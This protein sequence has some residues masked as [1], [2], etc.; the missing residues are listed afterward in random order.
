MRS[1]RRWRSA[2]F[3]KPSFLFVGSRFAYKNFPFLLRAFAKASESNPRIR[4]RIAGAPLNIEERWQI[5]LLGISDRV[6]AVTYPD[7]QQL[8]S[9]YRSSVALVYPSLHEGFGIS[10]L[11]AMACRTLAITSNTTSLPEVMA[12]VASCWIRRGKW[13]GSSVF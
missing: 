3:E 4:L 2:I 13:T 9:L 10:P 11:E 8:V 5:Q 6:E 1:S 7:E 12:M